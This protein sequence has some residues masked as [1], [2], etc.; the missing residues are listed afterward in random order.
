MIT[1]GDMVEDIHQAQALHPYQSSGHKTMNYSIYLLIIDQVT[2][3]VYEEASSFF[4][5]AKS[6]APFNH[7]NRNV[8]PVH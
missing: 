1:S 6:A 2:I 4:C 8:L 5:L 3:R 7:T